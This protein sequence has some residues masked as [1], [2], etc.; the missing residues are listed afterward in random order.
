MGTNYYH[1]KP[2]VSAHPCPCCGKRLHCEDCDPNEGRTHIGK[3][4]SGWTF[5]FHATDTIRSYA[6]WLKVL[7]AGGEIVNEYGDVLPLADF[8]ELV[9]RKRTAKR[10]HTIYCRNAYPGLG[11]NFLDPDGHSFSEGEFS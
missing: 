2:L 11:G 5:T 8:K 9:E 4:S 1:E 6:D 10:N 7:E 3:S